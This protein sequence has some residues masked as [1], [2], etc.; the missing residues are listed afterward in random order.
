[1]VGWIDARMVQTQVTGRMKDLV[2]CETLIKE[3]MTAE[4]KNRSCFAE[5]HCIDA[6]KVSWMF[7]CLVACVHFPIKKF[8]CLCVLFFWWEVSSLASY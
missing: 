5:G 1:M 8:F 3:Q 6:A 7:I 4:R 2:T